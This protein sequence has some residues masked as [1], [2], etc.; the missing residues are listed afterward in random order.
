VF[1]SPFR[2]KSREV[3]VREGYR[4]A[5]W[6]CARVPFAREF[7]AWEVFAREFCV[8][9]GREEAFKLGSSDDFTRPLRADG[10]VLGRPRGWQMAI[11]GAMRI[12]RHA[13]VV[14]SIDRRHS[15]LRVRLRLTPLH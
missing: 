8:A 6:R 9:D 2:G 7:C 1:D 14:I 5:G 3:R 11:K 15:A 10:A 13:V 4:A 12:T